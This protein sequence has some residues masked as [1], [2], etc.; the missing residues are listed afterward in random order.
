MTKTVFVL[1]G[2]NLNTL[3]KR[4]PGI[5]GGQ[6]HSQSPE[7]LFTHVCGIRTVMPSNP[8]DAKGLLISAIECNDPVV[9]LEPKRIYNGPF[10]GHHDRPLVPWSEHALSRVP[11]GHYTV[12]LE[13]ARVF[14]PGQDVT[15]L[16][17]GTMVWVSEAAAREALARLS[18]GRMARAT[19]VIAAD[20]R[21]SGLRAAAGIGVWKIGIPDFVRL[22]CF[23]ASGS[24]RS[25]SR[26][27]ATPVCGRRSSSVPIERIS[28]ACTCIGAASTQRPSG[29]YLICNGFGLMTMR[30]VAMALEAV[31]VA[32]S[33]TR[34]DRVG[35]PGGTTDALRSKV[36][37]DCE[38][39]FSVEIAAQPLSA[40]R[41]TSRPK[42]MT[43][44]TAAARASWIGV[45]LG[46]I[47]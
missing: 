40:A 39:E 30:S 24:A 27:T 42:R 8:Y 28:S 41:P 14:K 20:G 6:T 15:V 13:S 46:L 5:Y 11:E 45:M 21:D 34:L 12:P 17:Y 43:R 3:G 25:A 4:E 2:P 33:S 19:L 22:A 35:A 37:S 38:A 18:D 7:A 47:S 16:C 44:R 36:S 26:D 31:G 32:T 10:D 23:I 29:R 1:N 9:F